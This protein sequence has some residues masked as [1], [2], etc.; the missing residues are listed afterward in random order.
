[1]DKTIEIT[2]ALAECS[3]GFILVAGSKHG[4]CAILL[5]DDPET[6]TSDL[7]DRFP[8]LSL[9]GP[10]AAFEDMVSRVVSYVEAPAEGPGFPIDVLGTAFQQRVWQELAKIPAGS[11]A[12]YTDIATRIG[13]PNSIRAVA[14]AC[15]AN[16]LAVAI[17]C[18]RVIRRDGVLSGYRWGIER[19]RTLLEREKH[20]RIYKR[21]GEPEGASGNL[22]HDI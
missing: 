22:N 12:S 1:M 10:D 15:G 7:R 8:H 19:K 5:G 4:I 9:T 21:R 11:T 14:R 2:F 20:P 6:L 17:P 3:L 18:H 16:V 13:A